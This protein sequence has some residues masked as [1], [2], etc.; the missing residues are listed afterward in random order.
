MAAQP[1]T[2]SED[3]TLMKLSSDTLVSVHTSTNPITREREPTS[4]GGTV[5]DNHDA[6]VP[7]T[8]DAQSE[9]AA[10]TRHRFEPQLT[11]SNYPPHEQ[12][13][14]AHGG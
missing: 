3:V 5:C 1:T 11:K 6:G 10:K 2:T 12:T 14:C 4:F 7:P 9:E 8:V 13:Q